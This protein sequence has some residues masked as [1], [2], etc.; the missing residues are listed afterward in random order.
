MGRQ[1]ADSPRPV[2]C[3]SL[4]LLQ[5]GFLHALGHMAANSYRLIFSQPGE[6]ERRVSSLQF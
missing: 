4:L 5:V 6:P 1:Q 2:C 3:L